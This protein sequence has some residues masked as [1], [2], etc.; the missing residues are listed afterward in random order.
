M[1]IDFHFAPKSP[2]GDCIMFCEI[3]G[4]F[5]VVG[6]LSNNLQEAQKNVKIKSTENAYFVFCIS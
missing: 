1:V 4:K 2:E 6:V 5:V 3:P